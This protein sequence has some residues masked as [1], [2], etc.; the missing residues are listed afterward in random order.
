[1]KRRGFTL[2]EL[3][4]VI[5]IIAVLLSLLLPALNR[6]REQA[7]QVVCM[8]NLRH[9]GQAFVSYAHDNKEM[10][11]GSASYG[12]TPRFDDWV[13][14]QPTRIAQIGRGGIG[15]YL[16]LANNAA[17]TAVL[18]CPS[19]PIEFRGQAGPPGKYPFSYSMNYDMV[20]GDANP[21]ININTI[22]RPAEKI[23]LFEEDENTIDDGYGVLLNATNMLAIRHDPTRKQPDNTANALTLNK[24]C[25][26]NVAFGDGHAEY[27]DRATAH[28]PLNY[29]PKQ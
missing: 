28:N 16:N 17:S 29:D 27:I 14:W 1:M 18:R 10:W 12:G 21:G 13:W 6:S 20:A 26:G 2:I 8:N 5:G 11:P 15:P 19:D 23:L 9:I 4:I 3:L 22:L 25:R 24:S 7:R